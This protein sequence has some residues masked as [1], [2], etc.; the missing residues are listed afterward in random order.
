[1]LYVG[2][3]YAAV[4]VSFEGGAGRGGQI[5]AP[6]AGGQNRNAVKKFGLRDSGNRQA[7]AGDIVRQN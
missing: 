6:P 7:C 5:V 1:M 4:E 3:Q 2:G